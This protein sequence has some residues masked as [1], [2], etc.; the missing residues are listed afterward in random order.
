MTQTYCQSMCSRPQD[1]PPGSQARSQ[2]R[3]LK[4]R[5]AFL[6]IV[7][8]AR[9]S[10]TANVWTSLPRTKWSS[11]RRSKV[12]K[13]LQAQD[14]WFCGS[15]RAESLEWSG[16]LC[17]ANC[18]IE[19]WIPKKSYAVI[20]ISTWAACSHTS[21]IPYSRDHEP[22]QQASFTWK[23]LHAKAST[24]AILQTNHSDRYYKNLDSYGISYWFS[25]R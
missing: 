17:K 7:L 6:T 9:Y 22:Y 16:W 23:Q 4:A 19:V 18:L 14:K 3:C 1:A 11:P 2:S 13:G 12:D 25:L 24:A 20:P 8:T 15:D 5:S 21:N 10:R